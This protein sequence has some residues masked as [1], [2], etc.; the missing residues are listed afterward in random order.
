MLNVISFLEQLQKLSFEKKFKVIN[1][2]NDDDKNDLILM[3]F[4]L[5]S[6]STLYVNKIELTPKHVDF[7]TL[8]CCDNSNSNHLILTINYFKTIIDFAKHKITENILNNLASDLSLSDVLLFFK[9]INEPFIANKKEF[10]ALNGL[11]TTQVTNSSLLI[12]ETNTAILIG[13]NK[14][15]NI[16]YLEGFNDKEFKIVRNNKLVYTIKK[17]IKENYSLITP[18]NKTKYKIKSLYFN[19]VNTETA[20][21]VVYLD[22][23]LISIV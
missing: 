13:S 20:L 4:T 21:K 9:I 3:L 14:Y 11:L 22:N 1:F 6:E 5:Y 7:L 8:H 23:R 10:E 15:I 2:L 19:H 18:I 12:P 17:Y 16:F